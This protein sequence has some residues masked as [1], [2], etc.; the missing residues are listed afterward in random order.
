LDSEGF[1]RIE[2]PPPA[3]LWEEWTVAAA[4]APSPG[5]GVEADAFARMLDS[6][7]P[8]VVHILDNVH[9][10]LDWAE[11][12]SARGVAVVRT[13]NLAEDLCALLAPVSACSGPEG[14]CA[15]P[16]SPERCARCVRATFPGRYEPEAGGPSIVRR[17]GRRRR[18]GHDELVAL[19]ERKRAR[20]AAQYTSVFDRIVFSSR[21]WRDYFEA[22]LP[23]DPH[24]V[25]IIEMG[26]DLSSWSDAADRDRTVRPGEPVVFCLAA[27]LHPA[28]GYDW[29]LQAFAAPALSARDDY[30]LRLLG[31]GFDLLADL[32]DTNP[33]IEV[34]GP[35]RPR[36]MPSLLDGVHVGLSPSRFETF[37]RVTREYLAA[38]IPVIGNGANGFGIPDV[39]S[40]GH[41]GLL[42]DHADGA[43]LERAVS[44]VLDD[45]DLLG[46]LTEGS[47]AT[48][49]RSIEDEVDDLVGLYEELMAERR[50]G[51][52]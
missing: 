8:D 51:S 46:R 32:H 26:L 11:I 47:R 37:H 30:R 33:N 15:P 34:L 40:H 28:K 27:S 29:V 14:F 49:V 1:D 6:I 19:L 9:L 35:Y 24:R 12:A 48:R 4:S 17:L 31:G 13:P 42:C 25:R 21:G 18:A 16:L 36:D 22:T 7:A 45:R 20:A 52:G 50:S 38:G 3:L 43:S 41:N 44:S 39:V 5:E 10:P 2:V 23:L